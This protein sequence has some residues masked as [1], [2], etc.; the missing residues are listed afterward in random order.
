M[1][2]VCLGGQRAAGEA[3]DAER[4]L[5]ERARRG[6]TGAFEQLYLSHRAQ[7]HTLCLSLCGNREDAHDLVQEAFVRA[8][9]GISR[10]RGRSSF[11]TWLQRIA[12]NV[13]RDTLRRRPA[14]APDPAEGGQPSN[15]EAADLVRAAMLRLQPEQRLVLSLRFSQSLS[16][17]EIAEVLRWPPGRVRMSIHRARRAFRDAYRRA[18]EAEP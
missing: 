12:V 10:F 2:A 8:Y 18:N 15:P 6:D 3:G 17:Q 1:E 13:W 9:R 11:S 5:V 14:E 4:A 16:Y 7:A